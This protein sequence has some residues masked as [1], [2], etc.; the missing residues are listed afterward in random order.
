MRKRSRAALVALGKKL[1]ELAA[2]DY[3]VLAC[4]MG[5]PA[6]EQ[7]GVAS[8]HQGSAEILVEH[9]ASLLDQRNL[10]AGEERARIIVEG[11]GEAVAG[12]PVPHLV[13]VADELPAKPVRPRLEDVAQGSAKTRQL[14]ASGDGL[15]PIAPDGEGQLARREAVRAQVK[16]KD[17]FRMARRQGPGLRTGE[18]ADSVAP[19]RFEPRRGACPWHGARDKKALA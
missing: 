15:S 6:L 3:V 13:E 12:D 14:C 4:G 9:V 17:N 1:Q 18:E 10:R 2:D 19:K 8:A 11:V 5:K 7:G 16:R